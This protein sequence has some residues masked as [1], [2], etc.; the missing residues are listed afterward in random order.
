MILEAAVASTPNMVP[1]P[2]LSPQLVDNCRER[3]VCRFQII[4]VALPMAR[5]HMG[6]RR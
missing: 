5:L 6:R 4:S 2:P 3:K 1:W